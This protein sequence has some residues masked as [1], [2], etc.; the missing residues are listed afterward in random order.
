[1]A[2]NARK[3]SFSNLRNNVSRLLATRP[4]MKDLKTM[5]KTL[6]GNMVQNQMETVKKNEAKEEE[7]VETLLAAHD[8]AAAVDPS[9]VAEMN[10]E[11]APSLSLESLASG[12]LKIDEILSYKRRVTEQKLKLRAKE[13]EEAGG[14]YMQG[15]NEHGQAGSLG[16]VEYIPLFSP[17]KAVLREVIV[18][19]ACGFQHTLVRTQTGFVFCYGKNSYG[20]LGL[21]DTQDRDQPYS[22]NFRGSSLFKKFCTWIAAHER[23][24]AVVTKDGEVYTCGSIETGAL[25]HGDPFSTSSSPLACSPVSIPE[26][27]NRNIQRITLGGTHA[28]ALDK[29]GRMYTWGLNEFGQLGHGDTKAHLRPAI[30]KGHSVTEFWSEVQCGER[31]TVAI[32]FDN[33][34]YSWGCNRN[35]QCGYQNTPEWNSHQAIPK[36][37][38]SLFRKGVHKLSASRNHTVALTEEGDAFVTLIIDHPKLISE[39]KFHRLK[40]RLHLKDVV[41]TPIDTTIAVDSQ[42]LMYVWNE[43]GKTDEPNCD[44]ALELRKVDQIS[45]GLEHV[46]AVATIDKSQRVKAQ[47]VWEAAQVA[48]VHV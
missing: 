15:A 20:Q 26:L 12:N 48:G 2:A 30:I 10:I 41:A 4:T 3:M 36:M 42:G 43:N 32:G 1:M 25:G 17:V 46:A 19:V 31:H 14:V 18:Q 11:A 28:A 37:V 9:L 5:A 23:T 44:D 7:R 33:N 29:A 8:A 38:M 6:L 27:K 21:G 45:A 40:P 34:V 24:S 22:L 16:D 35:G 13:E 47:A 39:C